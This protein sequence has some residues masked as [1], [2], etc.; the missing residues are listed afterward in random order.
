MN[1]QTDISSRAVNKEMQR[2]T[3]WRRALRAARIAIAV[4]GLL[5][6]V[7]YFTGY[8]PR[9]S[10]PLERV[11]ELA[12]PGITNLTLTLTGWPRITRSWTNPFVAHRLLFGKDR[13]SYSG[14]VIIGGLS[15]TVTDLP[16]QPVCAVRHDGRTFMILRSYFSRRFRGVHEVIGNNSTIALELYDVPSAVL[17]ISYDDKTTRFL[18]SSWVLYELTQSGRSDLAAS[19]ME[20]WSIDRPEW[21]LCALTTD[22]IR[23]N[24][25]L[26][27]TLRVILTIH[28]PPCE[29]L[30]TALMRM[31]R[32]AS[33]QC[34]P[35]TVQAML[36]LIKKCDA[37]TCS[38]FVDS[39]A[40]ELE[41]S[42]DTN[43]HR[44][45][46]IGTFR[47]LAAE[48]AAKGSDNY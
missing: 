39:L 48:A 42:G 32:A 46:A 34:N 5:A 3:A 19:Y 17:S 47:R 38:Q 21:A 45:A 12:S 23:S 11:D 18:Y 20:H 27:D 15:I 22:A 35:M 25:L 4:S 16:A 41:K 24:H 43:D 31:I 9:S 6:T 40:S 8:W 28:N 37:A 10:I 36:S 29:R 33:P 2:N 44:R 26:D 1:M 14:K 13:Y 30:T 7:V